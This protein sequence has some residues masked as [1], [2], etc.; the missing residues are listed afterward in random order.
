MR[1]PPAGFSEDDLEGAIEQAWGVA[2]ASLEYRPVGFGSHHWVA[3]D[4]LGVRH[5]VTVD[6]LGPESRTGDEVSVLGLHLRRALVAATDLRS[7]G[8]PFVVAPIP[9]TAESPLAQFD[10]H[11]VTLYPLIEGEE[12]SFDESFDES[13]RDQ[14]LELLAAL[15]TV[16]LTAIRAPAADEFV[17]PWLNQL[18]PAPQHSD[19]NGSIGPHAASVSRLLVD[20]EVGIR[21]LVVQYEALVAR[22]R[23]NPGPVVVTHGEIHPGNVML[24]SKGWVIVDWDTVLVAPP[25]RD[26]WRLAHGG[27]S[28]L[29]AY[30]KATA[31]TPNEDLI[32]LYAIRWDLAEISSFA[33]EFRKPHEDTE[34]TRTSLETLQTVLGRLRP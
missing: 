17:V 27:T 19:A 14:L 16:P 12:F 21:R 2:I 22:H 28:V 3:V 10:N 9:T 1:V 7:F 18:D 11:A 24:T 33:E 5:F 6:Q 30:A 34:D 25:E 29:R 8:C 23:T 32:E 15:H 31:T 20:N 26:L 4:E 13:Q